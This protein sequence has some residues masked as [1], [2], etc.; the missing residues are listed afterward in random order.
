MGATQ[1][2]VFC[3]SVEAAVV[4]PMMTSHVLLQVAAD[5]QLLE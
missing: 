5:E 2:H 4:S 1:V 3:V